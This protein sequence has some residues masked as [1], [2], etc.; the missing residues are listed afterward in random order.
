MYAWV[1]ISL[2]VYKN[3]S[4]WNK[5]GNKMNNTVVSVKKEK[6]VNHCHFIRERKMT[7]VSHFSPAELVIAI[8]KH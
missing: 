1:F 5:N 7:L 4:S 6:K 8:E 3:R 2:A